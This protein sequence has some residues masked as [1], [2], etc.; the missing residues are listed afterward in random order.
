M[1]LSKH[2][3]LYVQQFFTLFSTICV[4]VCLCIL[5]CVFYCDVSGRLVLLLLINWLIDWIT[6][7]PYLVKFYS[8]LAT[9]TVCCWLVTAKDGQTDAT[10]TSST[11]ATT[12]SPAPQTTG[13]TAVTS[14]TPPDGKSS[15]TVL[16]TF[17]LRPFDFA[18]K[19]ASKSVAYIRAVL[20][21][22]VVVWKGKIFLVKK[23]NT[24][25]EILRQKWAIK[26]IDRKV[27]RLSKI[28]LPSSFH[29]NISP[30]LEIILN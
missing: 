28:C 1:D 29:S 14:P 16:C 19:V 23:R 11:T 3:L 26:F 5:C 17:W 9:E 7:L 6:L 27:T 18:F 22:S 4:F 13:T 21:H 25:Q 2:Y 30:K 15:I 12:T 20:A 8:Q 24:Y 10:T